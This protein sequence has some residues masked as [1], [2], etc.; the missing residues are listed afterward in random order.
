MYAMQVIILKYN[1]I[2]YRKG[3]TNY[4]FFNF[5][6]EKKSSNGILFC[7]SIDFSATTFPF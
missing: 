4:F 5:E 6:N 7:T 2:A 3:F 1:V